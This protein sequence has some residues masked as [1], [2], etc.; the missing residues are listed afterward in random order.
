LSRDKLH[1]TFMIFG[2]KKQIS[3]SSRNHLHITVL[4]Y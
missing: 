2:A 4:Q 1:E 3:F